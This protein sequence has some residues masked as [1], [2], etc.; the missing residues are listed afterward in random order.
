MKS[1]LLKV[2][3]IAFYRYRMWLE[4]ERVPSHE[5]RAAQRHLNHFFAYLTL[6]SQDFHQIL[7]KP[8]LRRR[9]LRAYR[10]FL[11]ES[12]HMESPAIDEYFTSIDYFFEFNELHKSRSS[13]PKPTARKKVRSQ[14]AES[15]RS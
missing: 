13:A 11:K 10:R 8:D 6:A 15:F 9:A 3:A 2:F 12:M 7:D 4:E 5:R 14:I 1:G